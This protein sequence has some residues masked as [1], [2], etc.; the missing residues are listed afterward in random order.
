MKRLIVFLAFLAVVTATADWSATLL[1]WAIC[2]AVVT[3]L[4]LLAL[5]AIGWR[6][7]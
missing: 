3:V 4:I 6:R 1:E 7:P 5:L 2:W